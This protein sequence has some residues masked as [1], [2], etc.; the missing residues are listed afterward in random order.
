MKAS[1]EKKKINKDD[2][3]NEVLYIFRTIVIT[4]VLV[5]MIFNFLFTPVTVDGPSMTPT[6][7]EKQWGFSSLLGKFFGNYKRFDV[8]VVHYAE[9]DMKLV[10]RIIGLPGE[11]IEYYDDKLYIDGK[12]VK[13]KYF[14][15]KYVDTQTYNGAILFT[16]DFGPITLKKNEYFVMGDN[17]PRSTDSRVLGSFKKEE[18]LSK[19]VLVLFPFSNIHF[20]GN[21]G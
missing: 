3:L 8:V 13:E 18:I 12:Y 19:S 15:K 6:L 4:S 14:D 11:T 20:A 17:R 5:F 2:I 16:D 7:L 1:A 21:G 10:K 9:K